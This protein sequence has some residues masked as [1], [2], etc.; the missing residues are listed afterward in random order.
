MTF[1]TRLI[2]ALARSRRNTECDSK[3]AMLPGP[4]TD[5]NLPGPRHGAPFNAKDING[6]LYMPPAVQ[7]PAKHD[8]EAG[9]RQ[10]LG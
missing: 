4:S 7:D 3:S 8:D 1:F 5:P 6:Q 10:R 2:F 9:P